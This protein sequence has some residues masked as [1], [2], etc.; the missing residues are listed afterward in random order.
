MQTKFW[1]IFAVCYGLMLLLVILIFGITYSSLF[2][3]GLGL[4]ILMGW[5]SKFLKVKW[6]EKLYWIGFFS[7][8]LS[9]V[10]IE[11][12]LA[13]AWKLE[14]P[15]KQEVD[16]ILVLGAGLQADSISLRLKARL[17]KALEYAEKLPHLPIILS[18]GQGSDE[19]RTEAEAMQEYLLSKGL[20]EE[21]LILEDQSTSTQENLRFSKSL[22]PK[23]NAKVLLVTSDYHLYRALM[24]ASLMGYEAYGAA[25]YNPFFVRI[26]HSVREFPAMLKDGVL[27][28]PD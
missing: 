8:L 6:L 1:K 19:L 27:M 28:R 26:D 7:F 25:A 9:F 11:M 14:L 18:G 17:D 22:L 2:L 23:A 24:L 20:S 21:L 16:C 4:M 3:M 12:L 13:T 15:E 5:L 10:L